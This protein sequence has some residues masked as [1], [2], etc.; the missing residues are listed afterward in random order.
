MADLF[1]ARPPSTLRQY[2][3]LVRIGVTAALQYRADFVLVSLG[4]VF[5][6][7][8]SLAF[9]G[10]ILS[11]FGDIAGWTLTQIAFVYGIRATGHALHS[12]LS[13]QLWATD[14]VVREGEF[15]RYLVRPVN[16]LLQLITRRFQVTAIGDLVFGV[17]V[18]VITAVAA[19]VTWSPLRIGYLVLVVIGSA[20]AE[21]AVMLAISALT[22]RLTVSEPLL[23]I[24]DTVFVTF[25]PYPVSVL[26]RVV[27]Y[28]LTFV[29]PLAFAGF[30]PA[31]LLLGRTPDL[32][33]PVWL[34]AVSPVIGVALYG[35]A[36]LF[37]HRQLRYY[38]S[39]GH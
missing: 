5:Y 15:D 14:V 24:I 23:S 19:P 30:F 28:L 25:G 38:A 26:P 35:L 31:A 22:F 4:A 33:V 17:A 8:A 3:I 32:F 16:P 13:G 27:G 18:L 11:A 21:S 10:V 1:E 34:A 7:A 37:F 6:E 29:V 12:L 39:P 2:A 9:V 20:C 36:V